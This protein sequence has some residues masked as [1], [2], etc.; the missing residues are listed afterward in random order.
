VRRAGLVVDQ[1][2]LAEVLS[3]PEDPENG[4]AAILTDE[5]DCSRRDNGFEIPDDNCPPGTPGYEQVSDYVAAID[6]VKGGRDRWAAAVVAGPVVCSSG[7]GN[8]KE[9][10][11]L[12]EFAGKLGQNGVFS[13]ICLGDLVSPLENAL[14]VFNAACQKF[15]VK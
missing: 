9:A 5:D 13:S 11:R 10:V 2:E 14:N 1:R 12:K 6:A 7:F 3:D 15:K 4:F 8:A